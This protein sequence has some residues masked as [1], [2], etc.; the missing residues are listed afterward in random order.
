MPLHGKAIGV[1][2]AFLECVLLSRVSTTIPPDALV[3]RQGHTLIVTMN[4][5]EAKNALSAEMIQIMSAA[6]DEVN[7]DPD[8]RVAGES[9]R[10]GASE[11][12]WGL[13]P[14]GGSAVR[15]RRQI[16]IE[17]PIGIETFMSEDAKEGPRAFK[18]KRKPQFK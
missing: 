13:F 7:G 16:Q 5:P 11:V 17:T 8:I 15:L 4:R 14:L 12:R 6:W 1:L 2:L 18:E 3:E 9:A 10:F